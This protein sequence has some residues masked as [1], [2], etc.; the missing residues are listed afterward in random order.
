MTVPNVLMTATSALPSYGGPSVSVPSLASAIAEVGVQVSLWVADGSVPQHLSDQVLLRTGTLLKAFSEV[1]HPFVVHDNGLWLPHNHRIA[2]ICRKRRIPR[3]ISLRGM[4]EPWALQHKKLKKAVAWR[5]YQ[6]RDIQSAAAL[7]ATS[8]LERTNYERLELDNPAYVIPN[9]VETL[10]REVIEAA[11]RKKI[12]RPPGCNKRAVF[13]GRLYPVKGLPLLLKAWARVRPAGWVLE[14]AGPDEAGHLAELK[15]LAS[16]MS[17]ADAVSFVGEVRNAAKSDLLLNADLFVLP[18]YQESFGLAAA[19][20]LAHG[21][22]TI[23][24]TGTPW[25]RL[26]ENGAGWSVAPTVEGIE[27]ALREAISLGENHTSRWGSRPTS[28]SMKN[29]AGRE[30]PQNFL[31]STLGWMLSPPAI[32]L[33]GRRKRP[34]NARNPSSNTVIKARS[35]AL[36]Q[37]QWV[38]RIRAVRRKKRICL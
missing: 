29:S 37:R 34:D 7:H 19:E 25:G 14:I 35:N 4:L 31:I 12:A 1:A 9:G 16:E 13:L 38:N 32:S 3:I 33:A 18:S 10:E 17:I 21:I 28:L 2:L 6:R 20:A 24:T 11:W 27:H 8:E 22:P 15:T 30:L 5:L 23:T 36:A 26:P